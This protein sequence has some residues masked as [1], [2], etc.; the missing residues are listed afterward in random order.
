MVILSFESYRRPEG[1]RHWEFWVWRVKEETMVRKGGR[2]ET[3]DSDEV[4]R[5]LEGIDTYGWD[6]ETRVGELES[7]E[8]LFD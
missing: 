8:A 3:R 5:R 4:T 1:V 6:L 2:F 7:W